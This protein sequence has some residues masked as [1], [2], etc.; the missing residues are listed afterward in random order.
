MANRGNFRPDP[1]STSHHGALGQSK[2]PKNPLISA[3]TLFLSTPY[4][5]F[6][7]VARKSA[8]GYPMIIPPLRGRTFSTMH[9]LQNAPARKSHPSLPVYSWWHGAVNPA[10]F[11]FTNHHEANALLAS[12]PPGPIGFDLEWRPNY[13]KGQP[14]NDVALVQLATA[15]TVILLHIYYMTRTCLHCRT[16]FF[17]DTPQNFQANWQSCS[18][19]RPGSRQAS[20]SNVRSQ[21]S[22]AR[23]MASIFTS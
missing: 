2:S 9:A 7:V 18:T 22:H 5:V 6:V 23:P 14:E 15:E 16:M 10:L 3:A 11:Y 13:R 19:R 17:T 8:A 21:L 1:V 4:L 12:L 20:A